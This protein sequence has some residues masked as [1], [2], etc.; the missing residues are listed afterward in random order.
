MVH[1]SELYRINR[2]NQKEFSSAL[3]YML[4]VSRGGWHWL[5]AFLG[6]PAYSF[7]EG[8]SLIAKLV[9]GYLEMPCLWKG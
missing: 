7:I 8:F 3:N 4:G 1:V 6:C 2:N 5:I 9:N